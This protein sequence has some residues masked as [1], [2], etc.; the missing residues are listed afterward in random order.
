MLR[1]VFGLFILV[2]MIPLLGTGQ[3]KNDPKQLE[4]EKATL[5]LKIDSLNERINEIDQLLVKNMSPEA[6]LQLMVEKYGKRKGP[7]IAEGRVW[8]GVSQEM[9]LDSWGEPENKKRSEGTWGVNETWYYPEGKYIFFEN[10]RLS[11]WKQ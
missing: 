11:D 3:T 7:M 9:A 10:G 5:Q 1:F 2:F 4:K 6:R 8:T